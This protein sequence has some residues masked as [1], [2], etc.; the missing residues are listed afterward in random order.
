M[1]EETQI[2]SNNIYELTNNA[3]DNDIDDPDDSDTNENWTPLKEDDLEMNF[4]DKQVHYMHYDKMIY[5]DDMKQINYDSYKLLQEFK[6]NFPNMELILN[7]K[8]VLNHSTILDYINSDY[9]MY[10]K[11]IHF[12]LDRSTLIKIINIIKSELHDD[13]IRVILDKTPPK[14]DIRLYHLSKQI[15]LDVSLKLFKIESLTSSISFEQKINITFI[16]DL[17]NSEPILIISKQ[18]TTSSQTTTK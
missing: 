7:N 8:P 10:L 16:I 9:D 13:D 14:I 1:D 3:I 18:D 11:K 6:N 15:K 5:F 2:N 4:L 17:I 12:I